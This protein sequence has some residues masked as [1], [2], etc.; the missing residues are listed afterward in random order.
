MKT[1]KR[2]WMGL[3]ATALAFAVAPGP[4]E[5]KK[6]PARVRL[7]V[8][9]GNPVLQAGQTQIAYVKISLT[10]FAID[11][12]RERTPVNLAIVLDRSGSMSGEKLEK[13]KEAAIMAINR[14][15]SRDI[16]SV[17][18]YEST[19]N[20]LLPATRVTDK[21]AI[22]ER[23][24]SITAGG[25]TALF[26]GVSKGAAEI[27]KFIDRNQVNRLILLSDGL[28]NIGPSSPG[29]LGE[30]G[31]SL[32]REGVSITTIGLGLDYNEDLMTRLAYA[33]DGN[34]YFVENAR[35]LAG[36]FD[37]ELGDV[38]T[39]VAQ[40]VVT[41]IYCMPH[42]RPLRVLGQDAEISG[43]KV[44]I[45]HNQL[46]SEAEKSILL[47]I[48]VSAQ[49]AGTKLELARVSV[50]Y[51]NMQTK[52]IDKLDG[53]IGVNF[54]ESAAVV[55]DKA[56]KAVLISVVEQVAREKSEE[57]TQLRDQGKVQEA[58]RVLKSNAAYLKQ[59][60]ATLGSALLD[61]LGSQNFEDAD[62][63]EGAAWKG[64]RKAMREEQYR[65]RQQLERVEQ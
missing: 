27:A 49:P 3:L 23:I 9:T 28:A 55:K 35:D 64:R 14:L 53:T 10:G 56:D 38:L 11:E 4:A 18:T 60:G 46:Y 20:V 17:I 58:K 30:L 39:V 44:T 54:T 40:E 31:R 45:R 52:Q 43:N 62:N 41:E 48:E 16:V 12:R 50:R 8:G 32:V 5:A 26:A 33:S 1:L 47:E 15:S 51:A 59:S 63:L 25:R 21:E 22:Q 37:A 24:A 36:I 13:A 34:H 6:V 61:A 57:A 29:E 19:V 42:I 2:T 7:D 65:S